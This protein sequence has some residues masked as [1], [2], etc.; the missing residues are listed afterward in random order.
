MSLI[1]TTKTLHVHFAALS[2]ATEENSEVQRQ[3]WGADTMKNEMPSKHRLCRRMS[4][5]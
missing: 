3:Y 2:L 4:L 5:L 1:A